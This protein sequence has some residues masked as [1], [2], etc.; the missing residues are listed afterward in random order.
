MASPHLIT[1]QCTHQHTGHVYILTSFNFLTSTFNIWHNALVLHHTIVNIYV[2]D[3]A[4]D[5]IE[6]LCNIEHPEDGRLR[7]K[8]VGA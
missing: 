5:S 3:F 2:L 7:P 1:T 4:R 8:Y 6:V